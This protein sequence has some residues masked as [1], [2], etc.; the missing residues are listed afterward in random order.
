MQYPEIWTHYA[1]AFDNNIIKA[2]I[3]GI[4]VHT[5][6]VTDG[7]PVEWAF[8][9]NGSAAG[10]DYELP[11]VFG[12]NIANFGLGLVDQLLVYNEILSDEA[13]NDTFVQDQNRRAFYYIN[14]KPFDNDFDVYV[15]DS[16]GLI[17]ALSLKDSIKVDWPDEHGLLVDLDSRRFQER[18]ITLK[19][20]IRCNGFVDFSMK[21]NDFLREFTQPGSQRLRVDIDDYK[22][23][24][25]EVYMPSGTDIEKKWREGEFFGTF[26]L[27]LKEAEPVKRVLRFDTQAGSTNT[28]VI[29]MQGGY[30][31]YNIYWGDG[32]ST[33][34]IFAQQAQIIQHTYQ[35]VEKKH[36]IIV[37]GDIE[38]LVN[39]S[40]N[41]IMIWN[42]L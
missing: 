6:L 7:Y 27:S 25:Y 26:T 9:Q 11:M 34:D 24:V 14:E 38:G 33:K 41:G 35:D 37:S 10:F 39:F 15:S 5:E 28:V 42:Q 30:H 21:V 17:D 8:L 3:N 12:D 40:H 36:Y 4:L 18:V 13:V 16:S 2:Y 19:C 31:P 22:Q 32:S 20:F 29:N 23:L 1:V